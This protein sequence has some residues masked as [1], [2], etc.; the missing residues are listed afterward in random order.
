MAHFKITET[1]F[2]DQFVFIE[3]ESF[4]EAQKIYEEQ[5]L[6]LKFI[7]G[8]GNY[9]QTF[10][11]LVDEE[12]ADEPI[13]EYGMFTPIIDDCVLESIGDG[14]DEFLIGEAESIDN[15]FGLPKK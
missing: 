6:N 2:T 3:A 12:E 4:V 5:R 13:E 1:F 7:D 8:M 11:A 9:E 14:E 15:Y 10:I